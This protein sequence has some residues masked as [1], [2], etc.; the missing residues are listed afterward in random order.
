WPSQK[1]LNNTPK[2]LMLFTMTPL[3]GKAPSGI[4]QPC[5]TYGTTRPKQIKS[6]NKKVHWHTIEFSNIIRTPQTKL[7]KR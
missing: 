7:T 1:I 5:H 6:T 3:K 4:H 2:Q